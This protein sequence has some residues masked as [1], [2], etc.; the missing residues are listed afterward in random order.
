LFECF[1]ILKEVIVVVGSFPLPLGLG[2]FYFVSEIGAPEMCAKTTPVV[3]IDGFS[4]QAH[5]SKIVLSHDL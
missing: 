4:S 2:F 1:I 3:V 5:S